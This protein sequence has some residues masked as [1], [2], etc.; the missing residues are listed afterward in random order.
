M[1]LTAPGAR[2]HVGVGRSVAAI[3][4]GARRF[5]QA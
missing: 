4:V 5:G 3:I 1:P 2:I